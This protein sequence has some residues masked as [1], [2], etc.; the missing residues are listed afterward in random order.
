M[1]TPL[2]DAGDSGQPALWI[3]IRDRLAFFVDQHS[4]LLYCLTCGLAMGWVAYATC[5]GFP[6]LL[7]DWAIPIGIAV[8]ILSAIHIWTAV[9]AMGIICSIQ[10]M[11]VHP[12]L[13]V[14]TA[15]LSAIYFILCIFGCGKSAAVLSAP[16]LISQGFGAAVPLGLGLALGKKTGPVWTAL[17]FI[18]CA[19]HGVIFGQWRLGLPPNPQIKALIEQA[20]PVSI[21]VIKQWF[22]TLP[23]KIDFM[24]VQAS[25]VGLLGENGRWISLFLQAILWVGVSYTVGVLYVRKRLFD[26]MAQEY[27][28]KVSGKVFEANYR[29]LISVTLV[30]LLI[31]IVG[32]FIL[33]QIFGDIEYHPQQ[34]LLGDFLAGLLLFIPLYIVL[35]GNIETGK[36]LKGR[37]MAQKMGLLKKGTPGT[38]AETEGRK[39]APRPGV[40]E[41]NR[42]A[43]K[44]EIKDAPKLSRADLDQP[45]SSTSSTGTR[46]PSSPGTGTTWSAGGKID[47][48][49]SILKEHVGGMGV[50]YQVIDDFSGKKYAVK[51]LRDDFL[52]NAEAIERF[53]IEAKTWVNLDH[54]ENIVQAML[55]RVV[56]G[57]PLLFL[58]FIDGTDLD[59]LMKTRGSFSVAQVI[60]WARQICMGMAHAHNKDIGGGKIGVIH[61]DL[62][63]ANI[64]ITREGVAKITDFG[65]AKVVETTTHLTRQA[66]GLGTLGYM[67]PEQLEDARNVDKRADIYAFGAVLYEMLTGTPAVTGD[68]VANLTMSI[69]T[70]MAQA[71][72]TKNP[73][74]PQ[75]LDDIV[76]K[77][78]EKDRE[79]RYSCF[80]DIIRAL[81][82]I[83]ITPEMQ[84]VE[85]QTVTS[86]SW[87][88]MPTAGGIS[89][90]RQT[91]P[92][93]PSRVST[94]RS[95]SVA[96]TTR[97]VSSGSFSSSIEAVMFIDMAGSTALGSKYGDNLVLE[98]KER[99][100]NM[101]KIESGRQNV[102]FTKGTGDGFMLTFPEAVNAVRAAIGIMK[103]AKEYNA[104]IPESRALNLRIG[105][106]F[107]QVNIDAD[108]DRHG[109]SCNLAARI[110]DA[111]ED[112]FHQTRMGISKDEL[113]QHNRILASEVVI[114]ELKNQPEFKSRLVG[115]FDFQGISGRSK[116][117]EVLWK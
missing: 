105:I 5:S 51:T 90:S 116:V 79:Q 103:R 111:K 86:Q 73:A 84:Q 65:L 87:T 108:G 68:S 106:H 88:P 99:L 35:E 44:Q 15:I 45:L 31:L 110:E 14:L 8:V 101:V 117:F 32:Y 34:E 12:Q 3:Q 63:P 83:T 104:G 56:E 62:K 102:L 75:A 70:K 60:V 94:T 18:W 17:A 7:L 21:S 96:R 27:L 13:G 113:Q 59:Q 72:S 22:S 80:E 89:R 82:Q 39:P 25:V 53:G 19:L 67:P 91:T 16:F 77:C 64:M 28:E 74:V 115:Y 42:E 2:S 55:F 23:Q 11:M 78:M 6:T 92:P 69:L 85:G 30:G 26:K 81:N 38:P 58:E 93:S 61:R 95:P 97:P 48:Q 109:T 36:R 76:L 112:Q 57:R 107:G 29:K 71:P 52:K 114:D 66:T 40:S 20:D 47:N 43:L 41:I 50:V 37:Q 1:K 24:G 49:Y 10:M 33:A 4:H 100:G 9:L 46:R 98:M 54:H